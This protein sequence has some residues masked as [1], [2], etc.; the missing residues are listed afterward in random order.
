M[1]NSKIITPLNIIWFK[2]GI[3]LGSFVAPIVMCAVF[4]TV[5]TPISIIMKMLNKDLLNKK[6][7]DKQSYWIVKDNSK[8]SMK[9]QF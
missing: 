4:F 6:Y 9:E 1:M 3:L 7:S 8:N 2:F 5:I